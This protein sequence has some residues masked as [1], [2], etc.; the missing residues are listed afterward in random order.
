MS[1]IIELQIRIDDLDQIIIHAAD[2]SVRILGSAGKIQI[3]RLDE[4]ETK[5]GKRPTET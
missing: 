1:R 2:Q 5:I 3:D 4:V